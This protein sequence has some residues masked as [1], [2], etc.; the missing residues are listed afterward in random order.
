ME[1]P[2]QW[3]TT[4]PNPRDPGSGYDAGQRGWRL[5]AIRALDSETVQDV[6]SRVAAC[7]LYPSHGWNLDLFI[8][9]KCERCCK[10][11]SLPQPEEAARE[12]QFKRMKTTEEIVQ[13]YIRRLRNSRKKDYAVAYWAW[14]SGGKQGPEPG[15]GELSFMGA[16]AV[17]I[18]IHETLKQ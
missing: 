4:S 6:R 5:H 15:K 11:L 8:E 9:R 2:W 10:K 14:V 1:K 16:Q 17:R 7:G 18:E 13:A 12:A 3:M